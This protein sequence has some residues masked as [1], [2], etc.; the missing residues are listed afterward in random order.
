MLHLTRE[1]QKAQH[2]QRW[3]FVF[4]F[5]FHRL[6]KNWQSDWLVFD[7]YNMC[8]LNIIG[9]IDYLFI[10]S[11]SMSE[12][13]IKSSCVFEM[14]FPKYMIV[15]LLWIAGS[16]TYNPNGISISIMKDC[17]NKCCSPEWEKVGTFWSKLCSVVRDFNQY[18]VWGIISRSPPT[19][20]CDFVKM[21]NHSNIWKPLTVKFGGDPSL[22]MSV[23]YYFF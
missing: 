10:E 20:I 7:R 2:F 3:L 12:Y 1:R 23:A 8:L 4:F 18:K 16:A 9:R 21:K 17:G 5:L 6:R 14:H 22:Q 15:I 11:V 19:C 13:Y